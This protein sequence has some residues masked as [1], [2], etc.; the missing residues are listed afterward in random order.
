MKKSFLVLSILLLA[1]SIIAQRNVKDSII[2]TPWIGVQYGANW[3][4][5][6]LADRYGFMNHVGIMAGYKTNKNWFWGLE[7]NFM[8]GND[9]RMTGVFDHLIDS[10]GNITDVNGDIALVLVYAR[11]LNVNLAVGK[12]FPVLSPNKNS[13]I[14]VHAG[15]GYL[16]HR[17]RVETQEQVIPQLEL[18]YKKGYDRFTAGPNAHQFLGYAFM[19]NAGFLNF[20][21]GFYIQEGFTQNKRTIFFDQPTIPVSSETRLDIQYGVKVGW[22]IPFYKRQPKEFYYN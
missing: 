11:G 4:S 18:D 20:Y 7:S 15:V 8:F 17:M 6:D 21:G 5:G 1:N 2:G 13:G 14:F 16:A 22:F 9:V 19:S 12:V 3:T 10:Q